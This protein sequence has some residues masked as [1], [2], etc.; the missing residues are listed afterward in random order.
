MTFDQQ[1]RPRR[2]T[3]VWLALSVL[4]ILLILVFVPPLVSIARYKNRVTEAISTA[5]HRPVRISSVELRAL[6]RPGFLITD[7][8]V[9]EDPLFGYE[10]VLHAN[11]VV[12]S[13][14]LSSL[15]R[16]KLQISRI[17]VDEAS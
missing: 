2:Q 17:S 4:A 9:Q 6:P 10:P 14:K 16:G 11:T 5:M 12:A 8:T 15:W 13:I 7:F 1:L 3:R